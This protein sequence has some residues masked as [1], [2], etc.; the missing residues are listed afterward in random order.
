VREAGRSLRRCSELEILV[1]KDLG[2]FNVLAVIKSQRP[3]TE[4][5]ETPRCGPFYLVVLGRFLQ[6]WTVRR[7]RL[8][9]TPEPSDCIRSTG[10]WTGD[11]R[12]MY[13]T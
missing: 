11:L 2:R 12:W 5:R 6:I 1:I 8:G 13:Q 7:S 4:V 10:A 3:A 9:R